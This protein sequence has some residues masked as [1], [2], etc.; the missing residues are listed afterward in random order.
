MSKFRYRMIADK[1]LA[2]I[3]SER[4]TPG[5]PVPS[6]RELCRIFGVSQVT[7]IHA[8]KF[9]A[10]R[11]ILL[12]KTGLNYYVSR[13]MD[14][15]Q[16][17]YGFLT[18]LFR[19]I[20]TKGPE[21]Y[22]NRIIAGAMQEAALSS[23]GTYFS[24]HAGRSIYTH[25]EDFSRTLEEALSLPRKNAGFIADYYI[26]DE[27]LQEI[28]YET[29]QPV[30]VIG[31]IS[32]LPEVH[33]VVLDAMP[34]YRMALQML[35]RL[36]YEAFIC[37]E[38]SEK[39]RREYLQQQEFFKEL[40]ADENVVIIPDY[41]Y[42]SH[43]VAQESLKQAFKKLSGK[44]VAVFMP[45]D[46]AARTTIRWMEEMNIKVPDD[47]G[48]IGFYGTRLAWEQSPKLCCLSVQP[49]IL[50]QTAVQQLLAPDLRS[51]LHEI[52]MDFTFGETI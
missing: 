52:P 40:T 47:A 11:G 27:I 17:N 23:F 48:V 7:A 41:T 21:F 5:M 35:K 26:P 19:N 14:N 31:R 6:S 28:I 13:K 15:L 37:C 39:G 18:M 1:I 22:G 43:V 44:R 3:K 16:N 38:S 12:H 10:K 20:S 36:G 29:R 2:D 42:K 34:G 9:L 51:Q 4:L 32:Q 49:E 24:A 45:T 30:V 46:A 33:S 50:G 8:L 25:S